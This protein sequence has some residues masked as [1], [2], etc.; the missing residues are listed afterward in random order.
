MGVSPN[1]RQILPTVSR[2]IPCL[3]AIPRVDQWVSSPGVVSNRWTTTAST[4]SS[5]MVRGAP[6]R[7]RSTNPPSLRCMNRGRHFDTV[8]LL[9]PN[10][11]LMSRLDRCSAQANTILERNASD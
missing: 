4:M 10:S 2:E 3:A 1:A 6:E 9:Q 8:A 7:G 11:T 5:V